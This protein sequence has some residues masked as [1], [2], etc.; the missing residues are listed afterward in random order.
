MLYSEESTIVTDLQQADDEQ[1]KFSLA[2]SNKYTSFGY[3]GNI[4]TEKSSQQENK[5]I[6]I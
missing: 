1:N 3:S 2:A 5:Y 6:K 4:Y